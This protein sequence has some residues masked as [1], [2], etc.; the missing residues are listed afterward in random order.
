MDAVIGNA[1]KPNLWLRSC[2]EYTFTYECTVVGRSSGMTVWRGSAFDCIQ[3]EIVLLHGQFTSENGIH[4]YGV[5]NNGSIVGEG[6]RTENGCYSS[7][8]IVNLTPDIIGKTI[9]C[10]HD[11]AGNVS[12]IGL[13][14]ITAGENTVTTITDCV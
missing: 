4:A 1:L 10:A 9:E 14:T 3:E 2:S 13:L 8:L 7:Q 12:V 11:D 6:H 5:C